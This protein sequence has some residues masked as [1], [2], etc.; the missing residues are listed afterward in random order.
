MSKKLTPCC[1][2]SFLLICLLLLTGCQP[3]ANP[4]PVSATELPAQ[5]T[6]GSQAVEESPAPTEENLV[7]I[8]PNLALDPALTQDADSLMVSRYVYEGLVTLDADGKPQPALAESWVVSD[9]Q[10][11]YIFK[12]RGN[13]AFSDGTTITPDIVAD[14]FNRWFD[15]RVLCTATAIMTPGRKFFLVSSVRRVLINVPSPRWTVSRKLTSIPC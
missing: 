9:D 11:D 1:G 13:A 14:N 4:T 7:A 5:P 2:L 8:N 12:L 15:H 3:T 6:A 10:L